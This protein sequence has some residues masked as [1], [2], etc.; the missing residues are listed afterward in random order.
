MQKYRADKIPFSAPNDAH[1]S[2]MPQ[3]FTPCWAKTVDV[4]LAFDLFALSAHQCS[5]YHYGSQMSS[6]NKRLQSQG[7][8]S[9]MAQCCVT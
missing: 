4:K 6:Q 9:I 1:V 8:F 7:Q 3:M 2:F 5:L